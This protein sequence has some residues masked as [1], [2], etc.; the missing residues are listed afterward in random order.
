MSRTSGDLQMRLATRLVSVL[1]LVFVVLAPPLQAQLFRGAV[2]G[3]VTDTQNLVIVGVQVTITNQGTN[4]SASTATNGVG[5]YRFAALEPGTYSVEFRIADFENQKFENVNVSTSQ[6]PVIN[7]TLR[8]SAVA[9]EIRV[10]APGVELT[11]TTPNID[12]TFSDRI[13]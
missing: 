13:L 3:T 10:T 9:T 7:A 4:V 1:V 5:V 2:S 8:P 11:K 12:Q 6:E